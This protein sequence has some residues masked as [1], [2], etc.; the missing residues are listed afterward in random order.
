MKARKGFVWAIAV[1]CILSLVLAG[2]S[3][4]SNNKQ[5][6]N[7]GENKSNNETPGNNKP[8][9]QE[10]V[11]ITYSQWGTAEEL[12][13]TQELL[14]K[15]MAENSSI[16]VKLEGKD[17]GTYWDGLTASASGGV[18]P[19]VMKTSFAFVSKYAELGIFKELD[20]LLESNNFD[21]SA[22]A[23]GMMSMHQ[24]KGKQVSLPIDANVIMF[25][26]NKALFD[27]AATNPKQAPY[28]STEPTWDE[29]LDIATKLTLDANNKNPGEEGFDPNNVKQWGMSVVP[30]SDLGMFEPFLFSNNAK[31]INDD[32][33]VA[34]NTP[35]A[36]EVIDFF[37]NATRQGV[38]TTPSQMEG[39]G[40]VQ[41][42][43]ITTGKVAMN[44]AGSWNVAH[45]ADANIPYGITHLPKFK[46]TQ[47]V[48]QPAGIAMSANTKH[49]EAA[50]KLMSWLAGAEGQSE[51]A[52]QGFAIP[53]NSKAADAYL[54][55]AGSEFKIFLDAQA[56]GIP[57]PF[58]VKKTD[59]VFTHG[60]QI[61]REPLAGNGD[62][63]AAIA[64]LQ[65]AL[66]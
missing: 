64:E 23:D 60:T 18:L 57:A 46:T 32:D 10:K 11:T 39:L 29:V 54:E 15:F 40:G 56:Y 51:L 4:N 50:Y 66:Q 21:R 5:P 6:N 63:D 43:A 36:R 37:I 48:V 27:D 1:I 20:G 24:F 61:M 47:T 55:T 31:L 35:E 49:E 62:V 16:T 38:N 34:L 33:T 2:C 25:Y 19:D 7:S 53:A 9:N 30:G 17:W 12:Q 42:L 65:A 44:I 13:R 45:Y 3:G 22:I 26:Y 28:P 58:S 14:D 8:Q 41:N 59:L 52:K